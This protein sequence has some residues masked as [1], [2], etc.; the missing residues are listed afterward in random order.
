MYINYDE[1]VDMGGTI[2]ENEFNRLNAKSSYIIDKYTFDRLKEL[3]SVSQSVKWC[4]F[5]LIENGLEAN[6]ITSTSNDGVSESYEI[7]KGDYDIVKEYLSN[8]KTADGT[9]ILY[10]GVI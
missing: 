2:C 4:V 1:Y 6:V 8:I 9:P 5:E 7:R 3:E 10:C